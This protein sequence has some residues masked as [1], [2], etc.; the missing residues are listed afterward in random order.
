MRRSVLDSSLDAEKS[1]RFFPR[2]R[3]G[4]KGVPRAG[5]GAAPVSARSWRPHFQTNSY[6]R[7]SSSARFHTSR[8]PS[9][10]F[11]SVT[12]HSV[13]ALAV[14]VGYESSGGRTRRLP[15]PRGWGSGGGMAK[16]GKR[17]LVQYERVDG[18]YLKRRQLRRG[19]IA[20]MLLVAEEAALPPDKG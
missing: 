11:R 6:L 18:Q 4:S 16:A 19:E 10:R 2:M 20:Q 15:G 5:G 9:M 7:H 13:V 17:G 1:Y 8:A 12:G 14:P 3:R